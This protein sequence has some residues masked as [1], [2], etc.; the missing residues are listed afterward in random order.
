MSFKHTLSSE[1]SSMKNNQIAVVLPLLLMIPGALVAQEH[2][3]G[4]AAGAE[5]A[6]ESSA[7]HEAADE[8]HFHRNLI[9]GFVGVTREEAHDGGHESALT[10]GLDYTRWISKSFGIGVGIERAYGDLDFTVY[11]IPLSYRTGAWK[12]FAGPGWEDADDHGSVDHGVEEPGGHGEQED[13]GGTEFLVRAGLEYAFEF[14]R[15]EVSPKIM[16]DYVDDDFAVIAGL[17]FGYGF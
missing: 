3:G 7:G 11:T 10:V 12:L 16:V 6:H 1:G 14:E 4:E 13:H 2:G 9:A 17:S 15:Y 5:A 8:H